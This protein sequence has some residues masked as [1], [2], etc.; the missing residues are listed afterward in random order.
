MKTFASMQIRKG[1]K[2]STWVTLKMREFVEE[3][4]ELEELNK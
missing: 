1:M 2:I 4:K 3:E